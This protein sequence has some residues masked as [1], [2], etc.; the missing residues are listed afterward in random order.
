MLRNDLISTSSAAHYRSVFEHAKPYSHCVFQNLCDVERMK[1]AHA[2]IINNLRATSKETDLFKLHQT[3]DFANLT[4]RD[5]L[6]AKL[7]NLLALR[8]E[9]Y[10]PRFREFIQSI[11]QCGELTDKVDCAAS[12]YM[13]GSHL[14]AHDDVISTRKVVCLQVQV[15]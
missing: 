10:S 15:L 12:V 11:T 3:T 13:N 4:T 7:P 1:A 2:E 14:V 9:I 5:E 8:D 6:G